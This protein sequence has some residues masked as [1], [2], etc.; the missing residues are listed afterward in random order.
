MF[1]KWDKAQSKIACL[2]PPERK[3]PPPHSSNLY[4]NFTFASK[5]FTINTHI[6]AEWLFNAV[7]FNAVY[8]NAIERKITTTD[9]IYKSRHRKRAREKYAIFSVLECEYFERVRHGMRI[10]LLGTTEKKCSF[11]LSST[12]KLST[13]A[14]D[15]PWLERQPQTVSTL[16]RKYIYTRIYSM[17]TPNTLQS[18]QNRMARRRTFNTNTCRMIKFDNAHILT[19]NKRILFETIHGKFAVSRH[20]FWIE[21]PPWNTG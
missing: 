8:K 13:L 21:N 11:C 19:P 18:N 9:W 5:Y 7:Y 4:L 2:K 6:Y 10:T 15:S 20:Q 1:W 16:Q 17:R 14:H 3:Q 12:S